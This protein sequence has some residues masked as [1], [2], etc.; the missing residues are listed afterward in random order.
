MD[1]SLAH[2]LLPDG[3]LL[4]SEGWAAVLRSEGHQSVVRSGP[5]FCYIYE[6]RS[7]PF[8]SY[9]YIPRGPSRMLPE[10]IVPCVADILSEAAR[11]RALYVRIEPSTDSALEQLRSAFHHSVVEALYSVQ[12]KLIGVLPLSGTVQEVQKSFHEKTRYNTRLAERKGV[13]CEAGSA[14][15]L[16]EFYRLLQATGSR[17]SLRTHPIEHYQAIL[18]TLPGACLRLARYQGAILA[19]YLMVYPGPHGTTAYYLHGGT[20]SSERSVM[21]PHVLM[22]HCIAEALTLGA[23]ALDFG[24]MSSDPESPWAGITRF[25]RGFGALEVA[26]PGSYDVVLQSLRYQLYRSALAVRLRLR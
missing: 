22:S 24:G 18:E 25:K 5:G 16:P 20:S 6:L 15:D 21:A 13:T 8:G 2:L 4:Q 14:S 19:A 1:S 23:T 7:S 3:G 10:A 12:P 26:L 11:Y 17:K 9:L